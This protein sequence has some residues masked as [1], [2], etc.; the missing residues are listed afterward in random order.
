MTYTYVAANN[1][2][3]EKKSSMP[4][5]CVFPLSCNSHPPQR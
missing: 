4:E 1:I 3:K 5:T 2:K